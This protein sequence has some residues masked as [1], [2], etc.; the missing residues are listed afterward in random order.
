ASGAESFGPGAKKTIHV[1][2]TAALPNMVGS[3]KMPIVWSAKASTVYPAGTSGPHLIYVTYDKPIDT[4]LP[5]DGV[6]VHRMQM[7]IAWMGRA[8][9]AGKRKP[10]DLIDAAFRKFN[11][12][13][14]SFQMLPHWQQSHLLANPAELAKLNSAG[15]AAYHGAG[16]AWP[17]S[18]FV[19]YGGECQAIVRLVRGMAHQIGLPGKIEDKYVSS[20]PSDPYKTRILDTPNIGPD[21]PIPGY[22]YSLVDQVVQVGHEY[23][24]ADHVGFNRFEAFLKYT[25]GDVTWF[26]G[27]IGRMPDDTKETDLVKVFQ[28]LV[29]MTAGGP[30]PAMPG[31]RKWKVV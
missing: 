4:G 15:F 14:L 27:G 24:A 3:I 13:I 26:G 29:A 17:L 1:K 28:G 19:E 11:G 31:Y 5:E 30:D 18:E 12:Y 8:W 10:V 7:T 16:G 2:A 21:G 22:Y 6:T 25:D 23:G 9:T 20:E